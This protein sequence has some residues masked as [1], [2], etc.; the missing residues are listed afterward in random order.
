MSPWVGMFQTRWPPLTTIKHGRADEPIAH[1]DMEP[2]THQQVIRARKHATSASTPDS[3]PGQWWGGGGQKELLPCLPSAV[4]RLSLAP[5]FP[6]FLQP[7]GPSAV[8]V[9]CPIVRASALALYSEVRNLLSFGEHSP[10]VTCIKWLPFCF[11]LTLYYDA[12]GL[13]YFPL[14]TYAER[15]WLKGP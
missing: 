9:Y 10:P 7:S 14:L 1:Q 11:R 13:S 8:E 15:R 3:G 4:T 12:L 6:L 5:K 2:Q